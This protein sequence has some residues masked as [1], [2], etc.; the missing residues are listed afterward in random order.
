MKLFHTLFVSSLL[1]LSSAVFAV[2]L[3]KVNINTANAEQISSAMSGIGESKA[4][5]IVKYRK[6]HGKFKSAQDLVNVKGIGGK[7]VAKN[8]SKIML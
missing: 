4:E 8:K 1:L 5:A 6:S 7:T 3:S 2:N